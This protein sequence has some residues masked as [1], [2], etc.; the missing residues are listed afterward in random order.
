MNP[1]DLQ[2]Q[3]EIPVI[4]DVAYVHCIPELEERSIITKYNPSEGNYSV[5]VWLSFYQTHELG[6]DI[7]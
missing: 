6:Y 2:I 7:T 1:V 4:V 5:M 3:I